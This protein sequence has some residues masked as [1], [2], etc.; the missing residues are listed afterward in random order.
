MKI[1]DP[2]LLNLPMPIY[3]KRLLI[4]PLMP[5]D[6]QQLF[7]AIE[8]T[9]EQLRKWLP[10]V[11]AVKNWQDSERTAHEFYAEFI[12]GKKF[13]LAIFAEEYLIGMS[14]FNEVSWNIPSGIIGYWCRLSGQR[15]GFIREAVAAIT[16][17][18]FREMGLKR[19]SILCHDSNLKSIQ[20]AMSLGFE[21]ETRALGLI[22]NLTDDEL[23]MGRRYV[24]F[25]DEEMSADDV[26]W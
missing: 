20:V 12:R 21:L 5:G 13:N 6:G 17:Y 19:V 16:L 11:D 22:E 23:V 18:A 7:T 10:W 25:G 4:R 3:T 1:K 2:L 9:R 15:N 24:R 26:R 8:E 14:G